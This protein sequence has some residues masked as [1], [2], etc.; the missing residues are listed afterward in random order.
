[1][2][3]QN[4]RQSLVEKIKIARLTKT[5]ILVKCEHEYIIIKEAVRADNDEFKG[6]AIFTIKKC[7]KCDDKKIIDYKVII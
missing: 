7:M 2:N 1:M 3:I 6:S 4:I 5:K